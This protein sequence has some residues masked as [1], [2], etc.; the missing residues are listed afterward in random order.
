MKFNPRKTLFFP[1]ILGAILLSGVASTGGENAVQ[2]IPLA[3]KPAVISQVNEPPLQGYWQ[4]DIN[5][6]AQ[7]NNYSLSKYEIIAYLEQTDSEFSGQFFRT[8]NN[9]C[10]E[11]AISGTIEGD[12]VEWTVFYTGSCCGGA[13]MKFEV[14]MVSPDRIEGKLSPVGNTPPNCSL[15]WADVV[16][17][18]AN[19]YWR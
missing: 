1:S 6:T 17:T 3:E 11:T 14:V 12:K 5:V 9:A 10:Q 4:L 13:S 8:N 18:R 16:I 7:T 15:W 19:Y 2:A